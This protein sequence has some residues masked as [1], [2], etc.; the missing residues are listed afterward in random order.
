MQLFQ[1]FE[2]TGRCSQ[3]APLMLCK[4]DKK[5]SLAAPEQSEITSKKNKEESL[6]F[7]MATENVTLKRTNMKSFLS[8]Q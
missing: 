6:T 3:L 7:H 5:M 4:M 8:T 2:V 1:Y